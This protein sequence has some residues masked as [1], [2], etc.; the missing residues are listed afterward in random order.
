MGSI[1][2]LYPIEEGRANGTSPLSGHW[3]AS[4]RLHTRSNNNSS[5]IPPDDKDHLD[6]YESRLA[7]SS[8]STG[9]CQSMDPMA[10]FASPTKEIS[11]ISQVIVIPADDATA[12]A[13]SS[14]HVSS[15][16]EK[17]QIS[18]RTTS[19]STLCSP[20]PDR[21]LVVSVDAMEL[22]RLEVVERLSQQYLQQLESTQ[23]MVERLSND[24]FKSKSQVQILLNALNSKQATPQPQQQQGGNPNS[25]TTADQAAPLQQPPPPPQG[26]EDAQLTTIKREMTMLKAGVALS[27]MFVMCGGRAE[28]IAIVVIVWVGSDFFLV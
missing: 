7:S 1:D 17:Q 13:S 23:E 16:F 6:S 2:V 21:P 18:T 28:L 15:A 22:E 24:L 9:T 5:H 27:M 3:P 20:S 11:F 10:P 8:S 26:E 14:T 19:S 12:N 25:T 4:Y